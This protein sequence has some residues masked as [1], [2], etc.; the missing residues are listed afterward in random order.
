[1]VATLTELSPLQ[2]LVKEVAT[3]HLE[4]LATDRGFTPPI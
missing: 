3:I 2:L 1:M 4:L